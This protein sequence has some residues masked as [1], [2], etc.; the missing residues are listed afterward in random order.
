MK[1]AAH[2]G[3]QC[4]Y[5]RTIM[6]DAPDKEE[7]ELTEYEED[8]MDEM[9]ESNYSDYSLRGMRWLFQR[10]QDEPLDEEEDVLDDPD[11]ELEEGEIEERKKILRWNKFSKFVLI[12]AGNSCFVCLRS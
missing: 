7:E 12:Q 10:E 1:N 8:T 3:F 5:C 6:A 4:P 9:A 11:E 2:N